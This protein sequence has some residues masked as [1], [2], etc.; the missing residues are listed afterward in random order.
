[1]VIPPPDWL[2]VLAGRG[3]DVSVVCE[4][5]PPCSP[6]HHDPAVWSRH[7]AASTLV[8][9]VAQATVGTRKAGLGEV[10]VRAPCCRSC[11]DGT[12]PCDRVAWP[13]PP[14]VQDARFHARNS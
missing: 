2:S 4:R 9:M 5:Q 8:P 11:M 3:W 10:A 14:E 7:A 1:M 6:A 13:W 12:D